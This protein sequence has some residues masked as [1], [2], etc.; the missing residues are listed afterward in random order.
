MIND[1]PLIK[2]IKR[3]VTGPLHKFFIVTLPGFENICKNEL[4]SLR[5][6][7]SE[8]KVTEGGI[9]FTGKLYD[10][11]FVNLHLRTANRILMRIT[12]FGAQNFRKLDKKL[13]EIPWELYLKE[14]SI[15]EI[16]VTAR[17]SRLYHSEAISEHITKSIEARKKTT[18]FYN[19]KSSGISSLNAHNI[20]DIFIRLIDD[21]IIISLDTS[22]EL[23]YKR[24]IKHH[25]GRAPI[26]ETI[27]AAALLKAGYTGNEP[28]F[29]PMCGTGTF[30]IE[31]AMISGRIPPGWHRQFAFE[32]WPG[33]KT[34][35]WAYLKKQA[36]KEFI[37][38]Y[39]NPGIIACDKDQKSCI[40][41]S[42]T[43]KEFNLDK[44]IQVLNADFFDITQDDI[45]KSTGYQKPG[46]V[47]IN[48]PY[49]I[50]LGTKNNSRNI[51]T[52]ITERLADFFPGWKFALFSPEKALIERCRLTGDKIIIDHGGI[53]L[54]L[55]T[56]TISPK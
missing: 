46:I 28:L 17:H 55:F 5:S 48:P 53:K 34:T 1:V 21:H 35:Q 20:Q 8:I 32:A 19:D 51:F 38:N 42:A 11:Y 40:S 24:G 14:D 6:D 52:E 33:F 49:G 30:S 44:T 54:T 36:G 27:A 31:A 16:T 56:G 10:C 22:G 2:R 23:L 18:D 43:L 47:I 3:H 29:D 9:E 26:R 45:F 39:N 7:I 25:P 13:K 15:P 12:E 41:L 4:A 50:R 37:N